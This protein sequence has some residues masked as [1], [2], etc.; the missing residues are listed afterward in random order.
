MLIS[1][2]LV[3]TSASNGSANEQL[4][5]QQF[6]LNTSPNGTTQTSLT[7][8][9]QQAAASVISS[10]GHVSLHLNHFKQLLI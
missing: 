4:D 2:P 3:S 8:Q 6:E 5:G 7:D 1:N 9:Q 10:V